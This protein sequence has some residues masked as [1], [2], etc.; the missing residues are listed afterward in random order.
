MSPAPV[1]PRPVK[2][3]SNNSL[4]DGILEF[5]AYSSSQI[6]TSLPSIVPSIFTSALAQSSLSAGSLP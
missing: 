6:S 3:S 4:T 5:A 2:S 1:K